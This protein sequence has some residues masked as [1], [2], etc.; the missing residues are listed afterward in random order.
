MPVQNGFRL[1]DADD[2][3]YLGFSA[4]ELRYHGDSVRLTVPFECIKAVMP[5]NIGLRGLFVYGRRI[6][7]VVADLPETESFE[8][9]ERSSWVLPASRATSRRSSL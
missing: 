6:R 2:I 5:Q 7:V 1:E 9:A 4:T 3:G 8:F